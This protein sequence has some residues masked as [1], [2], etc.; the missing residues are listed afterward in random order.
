MADKTWKAIER[1]IAKFFRTTRTPFSGGHSRHT[2]SDTLHSKLF[3]EVKHRKKHS[4]WGLW[5]ETKTMADK[6]NKIPIVVLKQKGQKGELICF[7]INDTQE[8]FDILVDDF[9]IRRKL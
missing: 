7:N 5:K 9:I 1:K 2:R 4:T 3:I 6:E 8:V